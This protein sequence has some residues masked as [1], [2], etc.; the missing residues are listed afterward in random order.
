MAY[1]FRHID[2]ARRETE[3]DGKRQIITIDIDNNEKWCWWK[4][5]GHCVK[6]EKEAMT[7]IER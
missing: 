3:R 4:I 2:R 5:R 6:G 7:A 1:C